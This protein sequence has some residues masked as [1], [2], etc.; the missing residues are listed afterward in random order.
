MARVGKRARE[1]SPEEH[2]DNK[3][4]FLG[5][6]IGNKVFKNLLQAIC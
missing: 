5:G 1:S 3:R 4:K 2:T 6:K